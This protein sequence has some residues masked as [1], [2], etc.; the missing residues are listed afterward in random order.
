MRILITGGR[1]RL[2]SL[3]AGEFSGLGFSV[4]APPRSEVDWSSAVDASRAINSGRYG[5]IIGCAAYTDVSG[6]QRERGKCHADTYS[7]AL[8]TARAA[9]KAGV[10][11]LYV[12]SDYVIPLLRG[13]TGGGVYARAK[14]LAEGAVTRHGGRV[15][16]LAFTTPEQVEGWK[17][18][19]AYSVAHRWWVDEAASALVAAALDPEF[20]NSDYAENSN[21]GFSPDP[22]IR[23]LGPKTAVTPAEL[24]SSRFPQH[25][26]LER[27]VKTPDEMAELVGYAA[28]PDSRFGDHRRGV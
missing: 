21:L 6:A 12:S 13:E 14:L 27:L 2:G 23:E 16:R 11:L 3:V 9:S 15:A 25:P 22:L 19:N 26:A 4:H 24:L 18:A 1:G 5:L 10:P 8:N 17:W 7:T 28:P 20:M